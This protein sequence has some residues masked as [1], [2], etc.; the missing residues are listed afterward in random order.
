MCPV[1]DGFGVRNGRLK[2]CVHVADSSSSMSGGSGAV[3]LEASGVRICVQPPTPGSGAGVDCVRKRGVDFFAGWEERLLA[4]GV[5]KQVP[6]SSRSGLDGG[7]FVANAIVKC[8][9]PA[10]LS[11][12]ARSDPRHLKAVTADDVS[13]LTHMAGEVARRRRLHVGHEGRRNSGRDGEI[14]GETETPVTMSNSED[15]MRDWRKWSKKWEKSLV[16][17]HLTLDEETSP[18]TKIS[19][20]GCSGQKPGSDHESLM[21]T[22]KE[23]SIDWERLVKSR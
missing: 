17:A 9:G 20:D 22:W 15:L 19:V 23:W 12:S 16:R 11:P 8:E 2:N 6:A 1:C 21:R 5:R 4:P 18:E 7:D 10:R 13:D 14:D 3:G